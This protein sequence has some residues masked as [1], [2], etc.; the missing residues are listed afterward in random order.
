MKEETKETMEKARETIPLIADK[1]KE[2]YN[3]E[4]IILY[5][6]YA[7]GLSDKDRWILHAFESPIPAAITIN[8][9]PPTYRMIKKRE[10]VGMNKEL[11][12][13]ITILQSL[14]EQI[15]KDY[16]AEIMGVFGSY[17]RGEQ[18]VSSD[19]DILVNFHEGATLFDL[20]GLAD[21]LEEKL[22]VKVD[23]V[24]ERA[25]REE[26]KEQILK[27]VVMV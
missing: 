11:E 3:P 25:I 16:K 26:L 20:V 9:L 7:W 1:L 22:D 13:I 4:K 14:E 27:E 24:S 8:P 10:M 15:K 2:R 18:K 5:G 6:S 12:R 17:V 23:I 21:F 19:V